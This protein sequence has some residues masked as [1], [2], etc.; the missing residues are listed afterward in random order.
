M[1]AEAVLW[2]AID[3]TAEKLALALMGQ[4]PESQDHAAQPLV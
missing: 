1:V 2:Q 3:Q 4:S